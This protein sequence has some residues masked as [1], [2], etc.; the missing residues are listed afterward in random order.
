MLQVMIAQIWLAKEK[1]QNTQTQIQGDDLQM[2]IQQTI[3]ECK[4]FCAYLHVCE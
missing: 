4:T 2:H 3:C 1:S